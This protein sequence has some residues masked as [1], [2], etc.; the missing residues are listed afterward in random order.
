MSV[1]T[2]IL[3]QAHR[4]LEKASIPPIQQHNF[5]MAIDEFNAYANLGLGHLVAQNL[6]GDTPAS[7]ATLLH[8]FATRFDRKRIGQALTEDRTERGQDILEAYMM[9]FNMAK[10]QFDQQ[11]RIAIIRAALPRQPD[12]VEAYLKTYAKEFCRQN[13]FSYSEV[14]TQ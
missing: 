14:R 4:D 2:S 8:T 10:Q 12:Q 7:I 13:P 3:N 6:C 1:L 11:L 9:R 5:H